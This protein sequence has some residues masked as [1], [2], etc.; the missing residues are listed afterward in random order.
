M[1]TEQGALDL[2]SLRV[3]YDLAELADADAPDEPW[4]LVAQWLQEALLSDA[5]EPSAMSVATVDVSGQPDVRVVLLKEADRRG[6]VFYT[7][8]QS[9]KGKQLL[10]NPRAALALWWAP[11]QRQLRVEG[12]VERTTAEE[13]AAYFASRPRD[14]QLGAWTSPQSEQIASREA[15]QAR[16]QEVSD[17]FGPDGPIPPP[18]HWGG[19]RVVPSRIEFWQ[20][21]PSR[22]HD[23]LLYVLDG[24]GQWKRARLAP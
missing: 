14:S 4:P 3:H 2:A 13:T 21:R 23:R 18:P 15:L 12:R 20:G 1:A 24:D 6:F 9:S 8:Y 22:L 17:R 16:W 7:N 10:A 5:P 11:L 19:Y